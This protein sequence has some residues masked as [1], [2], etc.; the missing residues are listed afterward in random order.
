VMNP[1]NSAIDLAV[2]LNT[3]LG[4]REFTLTYENIMSIVCAN[5]SEHNSCSKIEGSSHRAEEAFLGCQHLQP[6]TI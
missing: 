6:T 5:V 1:M 4:E 2:M 3:K